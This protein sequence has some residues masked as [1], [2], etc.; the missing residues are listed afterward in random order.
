MSG[1][2]REIEREYGRRRTLSIVWW[3][4]VVNVV[5]GGYLVLDASTNPYVSRR[6]AEIVVLALLLGKIVLV[7][8]YR[9][10][11]RTIVGAQGIRARNAV[12]TVTRS[13]QDIYDIRAELNTGG[14]TENA[15]WATYVYGD[16]GRRT[17]LPYFDDW[18]LPDFHAELADLRDT[19][20]QHRGMAW[21]LRPEVEDRIRLRARHRMVSAAVL[22]TGLIAAAAAFVVMA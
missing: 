14:R 9:Q 17:L 21:E 5:I 8:L 12:R 2:E 11:G 1:I 15:E 18:Q 4:A 19:A 7:L 3:Q 10:R 22:V 20:A 6:G 16:D 13:W